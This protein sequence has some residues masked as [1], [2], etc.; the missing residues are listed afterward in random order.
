MKI[1]TTAMAYVCLGSTGA[2][3]ADWT[4]EPFIGSSEQYTDNVNST[5]SG[6][7]SDF[8]TSLDL[9]FSLVGETKRTELDISYDLSQDYY[10]HHSELNG[11]RQNLIG[12]GNIE[13]VDDRFFVDGRITFTEETLGSTGDTSAGDRTQSGGR[14]QV[15]NGNISPYYIQNFGGWGTGIAR[16]GYS[17][18]RFLEANV[19]DAGAP[20]AD[21]RTN[22]FQLNFASGI[23]FSDYKWAWDN[24]LLVSESSEDESFQ[25]FASVG[26]GELPLN[27]MF[28]LIGTLGYDDFDADD[29]DNSEI[30]GLFGGAGIRFHPSSRTDVSAQIGYRFGDVVY[31]V[32]LSYAPTSQDTVTGSY[33]VNIQSASESLADTDILDAQGDLIQPEFSTTTYVDDVTKTKTLNLAWSGSRGRNDY[34]LSSSFIE[35][36]VLST[37]SSDRVVSMRGNFGRQITPRADISLNAGYNKTMDGQTAG[38]QDTVYNFG[39]SYN[40]EFGNGLTGTAAYNFLER[41]NDTSGDVTENSLTISIRKS[42]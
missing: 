36:E 23:R 29:V 26:T 22:E 11:Y 38:D 8:V 1:G 2:S 4:F 34:G 5:A 17:E 10:L 27:R 15:F 14:T 35:R 42:F 31:D 18:T 13:I 30:S 25:H 9:G 39:S 24:S 16:Y 28:S 21:Q 40:Y 33:I 6:A 20:P 12:N 32:D 3:A 19:G 7:E 37:E 41:Q